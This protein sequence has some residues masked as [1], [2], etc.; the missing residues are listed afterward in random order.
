MVPIECEESVRK[1]ESMLFSSRSAIISSE[2]GNNNP[3]PNLWAERYIVTSRNE[4]IINFSGES[5]PAYV[6]IGD[7][8]EAC[9]GYDFQ[10]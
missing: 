9:P 10:I 2:R 3:K 7:A 6:A 5:L 1:L 8:D 4:M